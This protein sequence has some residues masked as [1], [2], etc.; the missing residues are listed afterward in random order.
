MS[1]VHEVVVAR[2]S[3]TKVLGLSLITNIAVLGYGDDVTPANHEE[4][5]EAGRKRSVDMKT[6]VSTIVGKI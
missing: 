5:L 3:G 2:H 1:T 6:L 4:V